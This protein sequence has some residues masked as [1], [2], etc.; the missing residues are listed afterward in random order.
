M[1]RNPRRD[2]VA[3]S[4][5]IPA[6]GE[7]SGELTSLRPSV[8]HFVENGPRW[9]VELL[10]GCLFLPLTV[11]AQ[12]ATPSPASARLN[13]LGPENQ[14]LVQ[15]VGL[16]DVTETVWT[17]PG[18]TPVTTR[19]LVAER[20]MLGSLL[21]EFLRLPQD[22]SDKAVQRMDLL[23]F[24]RIEGRWD[25]VSFD[26]RAPVGLM[27]A[28]SNERGDGTTIALTF[29][30]FAVPGPGTEVTGQLLRMEQIIRYD[31]P[32]RD[33]K[34]QYFTLA[35]GTGTKWLAHRYTYARRR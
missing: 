28:W 5:A 10:A 15:R 32:D 29:A 27:P 35:D 25:Y 26:M 8:F 19:G 31:G 16:W 4:A 22:L 6:L 9:L 17:A 3:L 7:V 21:Q 14:A 2:A 30:P 34:E 12:Q 13:E 18:V 33:V 23:S 24:N 1:T 20:R 11:L